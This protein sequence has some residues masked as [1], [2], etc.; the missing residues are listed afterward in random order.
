MMWI[1]Y[2]D[3]SQ[4]SRLI[5]YRDNLMIIL[6][7]CALHTLV[8]RTVSVHY[9]SIVQFCDVV[10]NV[11]CLQIGSTQDDHNCHSCAHKEGGE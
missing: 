11:C 3:Y 9:G 10:V 5:Q 2:Y 6:H 8:G 7:I 4:S 1:F